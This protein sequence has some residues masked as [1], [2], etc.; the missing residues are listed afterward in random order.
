MENNTQEKYKMTLSMSGEVFEC[1][2][3][4]I[5]SA[6]KEFKSTDV[7]TEAYLNITKGGADFTR[8]LPL[9]MA[10]RLFQDDDFL[11]AFITNILF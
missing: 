3:D 5:K 10:K 8:R 11:D 2:T 6:L 9:Q 4:D 7:H 1:E